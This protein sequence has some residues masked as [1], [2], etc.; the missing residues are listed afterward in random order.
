[1]DI[2]TRPIEPTDKALLAAAWDRTSPES[3]YRR[4]LTPKDDLSAA[5]LRYLTEVDH[6]DHEALLA[7]DPQTGWLAGVAR[8]VRDREDPV[9]AEVAVVVADALHGKG[10]GRQ[11]L[12]R[13]SERARAEGIRRFTALMLSD[14]AAMEHLLSDLGATE[15]LSSGDGAIQ[16]AVD[17]PP[18]G[19]GDALAAWLRSVAAGS[20]L[21]LP[22]P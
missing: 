3:R 22:P 18:R 14:N 6:R 9:S 16:L 4:F 19:L 8:Y 13:L 21:P 2:E 12:E 10:I 1:M 5:E 11:L 15:L 20:L 7:I 17:L